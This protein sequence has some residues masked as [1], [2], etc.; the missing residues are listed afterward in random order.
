MTFGAMHDHTLF[1]CMQISRIKNDISIE[2]SLWPRHSV[3]IFVHA[4]ILRLS[5]RALRLKFVKGIIQGIWVSYYV[6]IER[7]NTLRA[8]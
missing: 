4:I 3:Q 1:L 7:L 8:I 6:W 5:I 2:K